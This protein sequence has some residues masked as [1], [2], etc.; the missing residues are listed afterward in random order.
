M[1][2]ESQRKL[3]QLYFL[4]NNLPVGCPSKIVSSYSAKLTRRGSITELCSHHN[5]RTLDACGRSGHATGTT[6]DSYLDK[7]FIAKRLH[8][9]KALTDFTDMDADI[10]A[11]QLECLG[12][13]T[14]LAV[15]ELMKQLFIVSVTA[16][17]LHYA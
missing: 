6:L 5:I 10:K 11:P 2:V 14:A 13:H 12:T 3:G 16:F 15:Q 17:Q 4:R 9:G 7:S 8:G 1:I